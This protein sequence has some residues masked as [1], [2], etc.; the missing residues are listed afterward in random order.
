MESSKYT[1]DGRGSGAKKN[2]GWTIE[3]IKHLNNKIEDGS[4]TTY[5]DEEPDFEAEHDITTFAV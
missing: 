4:C 3:N 5:D 1:S 2:Q